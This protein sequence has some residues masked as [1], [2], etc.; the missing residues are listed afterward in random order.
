MGMI[1]IRPWVAE[2]IDYVF[3]SVSRERWGHTRHDIERCWH[4]ERGGCLVA[5]EEQ[6]RVGHVSAISYGGLGWIGLLIVSPERRGRHIGTALMTK[7][8]NHLRKSGAET[9]R[10]EAVEEA[11]PLYASL[12]FTEEFES[13][14][15]GGRMRS[16]KRL[17]STSRAS[18]VQSEDLDGLAVFDSGYFGSRRDRVLRVLEKENTQHCFLVKGAKPLGYVMCRK[19]Q[20]GY[21][22]GPWACADPAIAEELL[23]AALESI[24]EPN[25]ILRFG[26]PSINEEMRMLMDERNFKL[27]GKSIRM[28][29]GKGGYRGK[30]EHVFGIAGPEKG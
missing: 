17:S 29:L 1:E 5:E 14:R 28:V 18:L 10:L 26:F 21:W 20:N 12:G 30:P 25:A 9:I 19:T 4:W 6:E 27:G 13:L 3:D 23:D 15:Y 2:D 7:A 8:I 16:A 11:V 22:M 24:N